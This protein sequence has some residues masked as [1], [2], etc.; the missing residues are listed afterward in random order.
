MVQ[1]RNRLV[2]GV[3]LIALS[4]A[5]YAALGLLSIERPAYVNVRWAPSIDPAMMA[6]LERARDLT[7]GELM[8]PRTWGYYLSDLSPENIRLLVSSPA[9][10]DTHFIDR[11][12]FQIAPEAE[13]GPYANWWD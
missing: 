3:A 1:Q 11:E 4:G 6:R 5:L 8:P 7:R 12:T 13:R 10:E 9:V 2:I